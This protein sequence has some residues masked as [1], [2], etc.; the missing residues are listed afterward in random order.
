MI[1]TYIG[2]KIDSNEWVEGILLPS[3]NKYYISEDNNSDIYLDSDE[4]FDDGSINGE[5]RFFGGA[6]YEVDPKTLAI[7]FPTMTDNNGKKIFASLDSENGVGG[8]IV[9]GMSTGHKHVAVFN[10]QKFLYSNGNVELTG[11]IKEA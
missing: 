3:Q 2:K 9:T 1:P 8:D 4:G 5:I 7:H 11:K 10:G 6:I